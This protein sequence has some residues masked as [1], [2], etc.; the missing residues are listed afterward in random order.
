MD[1]CRFTRVLRGISKIPNIAIGFNIGN[2]ERICEES[3]QRIVNRR[4]VMELEV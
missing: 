3:E 1:V 4:V 2:I